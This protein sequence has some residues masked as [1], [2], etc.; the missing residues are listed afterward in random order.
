MWLCQLCLTPIWVDQ[1]VPESFSHLKGFAWPYTHHPL[2]SGWKKMEGKKKG[3]LGFVTLR[4]GS[5]GAIQ[6]GFSS[7]ISVHSLYISTVFAQF[8]HFPSLGGR[9]DRE[10]SNYSKNG[11]RKR[12]ERKIL[13]GGMWRKMV[14][15]Y[16][17]NRREG[18]GP[19]FIETCSKLC[20]HQTDTP[21]TN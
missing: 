21:I 12:K 15:L 1:R 10:S 2:E 17:P 11:G 4:V 14:G 3:G 13:S 20:P 16:Q 8:R 5:P 18:S 6:N 9:E 7:W 19:W